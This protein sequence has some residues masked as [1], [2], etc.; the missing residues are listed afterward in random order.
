MEEAASNVVLLRTKALNIVVDTG[1]LGDDRK[2]VDGLKAEGLTLEDIDVVVNTH[3][4]MDHCGCNDLFESARFYAHRL[5]NPPAGTARVDGD[6]TL[7][8]GVRIVPTPGHTEGSISLFVEADHKY[9]VCG[10]AIPTKANYDAHVPPAVNIDRRLALASLDIIASWADIV[11]PGH[12]P[13][14]EVVRKK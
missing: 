8:E 3:L 10:D 13:P 9:A 6:T 5:E 14:F 2:I 1:A 11:V 12:E 7:T 4:H